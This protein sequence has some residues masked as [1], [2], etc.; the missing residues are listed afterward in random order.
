MT[1]DLIWRNIAFDA[2]V[3]NES[4]T[5]QVRCY[6]TALNGKAKIAHS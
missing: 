2:G 6:G 4:Q 5:L 3:E 1:F